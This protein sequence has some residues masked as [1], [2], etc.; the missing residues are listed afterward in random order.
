MLLSSVVGSSP[1]TRLCVEEDEDWG[2]DEFEDPDFDPLVRTLIEPFLLFFARLCQAGLR[3]TKSL[4]QPG[5][6]CSATS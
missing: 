4:C 6:T 1:I 5:L 3:T 2:G